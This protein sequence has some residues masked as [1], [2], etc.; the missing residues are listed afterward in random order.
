MLTISKPLSAGQ[1]QT[2]HKEEFANAQEGVRYG[3]ECWSRVL[4][5]WE[6][7]RQQGLTQHRNWWPEVY[8]DAC[9]HW[10]VQPDPEVLAYSTS[11]E[12]VRPDL[13]ELNGSA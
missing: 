13:K 4:M 5:N 6:N 10:G 12:N 7:W 1:A 11:Y 9:R 2:Y 3:D 8:R